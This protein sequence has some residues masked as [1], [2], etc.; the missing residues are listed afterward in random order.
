M[1]LKGQGSMRSNAE[2]KLNAKIAPIPFESSV[3]GAAEASVGPIT[4][5]F[6]RFPIRLA[7]PFMRRRPELP[8]IAT[9]GGFKA[10]VDQFLLKVEN[11]TLRL[12]GILGTKG[13]EGTVEG[14]IACNTEMKMAG[15]LF[16]KVGLSTLDLGDEP[17]SEEEKWCG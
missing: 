16:G 1:K 5:R 17:E 3:T 2:A 6:S 8:L 15:K 11:A 14:N 7:I 9:I 13:M 4:A 10:T 12:E